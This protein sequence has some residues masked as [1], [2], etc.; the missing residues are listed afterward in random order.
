MNLHRAALALAL[1]LA[2]AAP[3]AAQVPIL[4]RTGAWQTLGGPGT[5][6]PLLCGLAAQDGARHLRILHPRG[7]DE[8]ALE[9]GDTAWSFPAGT[10]LD[11]TLQ[12]E[13]LRPWTEEIAARTDPHGRPQILLS[14]HTSNLDALLDEFGR[15]SHLHVRFRLAGTTHRWTAA[16]RGAR[17]AAAR[18]ESCLAAD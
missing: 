13:G 18:L 12:F 14:L 17:T 5:D 15:A 9:I 3:A 2:L 1:P 11:V 10:A 16:L 7:G 6:T 8:I 4:G